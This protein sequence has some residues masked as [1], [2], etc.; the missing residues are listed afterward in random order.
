M[1]IRTLEL[2]EHFS[3]DSGAAGGWPLMEKT[4]PKELNYLLVRGGDGMIWRRK[5]VEIKPE[6][7]IA[8]LRARIEG[9]EE[10]NERLYRGLE[11]LLGR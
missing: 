1:T 8:V 6:H 7:T 5:G 10:D 9:L 3:P 2:L 4:I 11:D